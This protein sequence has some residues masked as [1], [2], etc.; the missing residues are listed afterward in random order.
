ME[1]VYT[2]GCEESRHATRSAAEEDPQSTYRL[3]SE[4]SHRRKPSEN[5]E[6]E[7]YDEMV[8][9]MDC[10]TATIGDGNETAERTSRSAEVN[11]RIE[12][13]QLPQHMSRMILQMAWNLEMIA[14]LLLATWQPAVYL[15]MAI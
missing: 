5:D 8:A 2:V 7:F 4:T 3:C 1:Q 15:S 14:S 11:A 12:V 10:N 6:T 9:N 13:Q